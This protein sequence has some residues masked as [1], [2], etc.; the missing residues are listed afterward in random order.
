MDILTDE[1]HVTPTPDP[2]KFQAG[3]IG[4]EIIVDKCSSVKFQSDCRTP[5]PISH[6]FEISRDLALRRLIA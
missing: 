2:L 1:A 3:E 5:T 6:D 4:V